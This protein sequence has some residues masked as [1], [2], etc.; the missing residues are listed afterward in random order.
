[1]TDDGYGEPEADSSFQGAV[2]YGTQVELF[3]QNGC[4]HKDS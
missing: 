2:G 4:A 1:L 3:G